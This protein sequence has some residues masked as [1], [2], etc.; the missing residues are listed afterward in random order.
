[1][2]KDLHDFVKNSNPSLSVGAADAL[3]AM[4]GLTDKAPASRPAVDGSKP[5][6]EYLAALNCVGCGG[7]VNLNLSSINK[8]SEDYGSVPCPFCHTQMPLQDY[9]KI[10]IS[11]TEEIKE[12]PGDDLIMEECSSRESQGGSFEAVNQLKSLLKSVNP[13]PSDDAIERQGRVF[14]AKSMEDEAQLRSVFGNREQRKYEQGKVLQEW[15]RIK[16]DQNKGLSEDDVWAN[17][18]DRMSMVAESMKSAQQALRRASHLELE[19][20]TSASGI[21]RDRA[22]ELQG[23]SVEKSLRMT[24]RLAIGGAWLTKESSDKKSDDIP[25]EQLMDDFILEMLDS[26]ME[27]DEIEYFANMASAAMADS[28]VSL[29]KSWKWQRKDGSWWMTNPEGGRPIPY[30]PQDTFSEFRSG[31]LSGKDKGTVKPKVHDPVKSLSELP[32]E[33]QKKVN[34]WMS[35]LKDTKAIGQTLEKAHARLQ[36]SNYLAVG[37]IPEGVVNVEAFKEQNKVIGKYVGIGKSYLTRAIDAPEG[38]T[39][40][41]FWAAISLAMAEQSQEESKKR[42]A[43]NTPYFTSGEGTAPDIRDGID[44]FVVN[45]HAKWIEKDRKKDKY[46]EAE[47]QQRAV[48]R[49]ENIADQMTNPLKALS[50]AQA[51]EAMGWA[52]QAAIFMALHQE[53]KDLSPQERKARYFNRLE[54]TKA[55]KEQIK[56]AI[57]ARKLATQ[58]KSGV[59]AE[60]VIKPEKKTETKPKVEK[61]KAEAPKTEPKKEPKKAAP[62]KE[63]K[64]AE[65]PSAKEEPKKVTEDKPKTSLKSELPK[66]TATFINSLVKDPAPIKEYDI[67]ALE[68]LR[69]EVMTKLKTMGGNDLKYLLDDITDELKR[70]RKA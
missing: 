14:Q 70:K 66:N 12:H 38:S 55:K 21:F 49:A 16:D 67:S 18:L 19:G 68:A 30:R 27:L 53:L 9:A 37:R 25:F 40:Q 7:V 56:Q 62:K 26:N 48:K 45:Q 39:Q 23:K 1:M 3:A 50:R 65:S 42:N 60:A 20:L 63:P 15:Q 33:L 32:E 44:V 35:G 57:L 22:S 41:K 34:K 31:Y 29:E 4:N 51:Y 64:K 69:A 58:A 61:P 11:V 6:D 24:D 36:R 47:I 13:Y 46:T 8:L 2:F 52:D 43:L 17:H 5:L 59:K 54:R 10:L 28:D